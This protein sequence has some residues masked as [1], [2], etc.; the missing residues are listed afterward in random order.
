MKIEINASTVTE[1]FLEEFDSKGKPD[2]HNIQASH[3]YYPRRNTGISEQTLK[4]KNR[5]LKEFGIG[6]IAAFIPSLTG[7]RGPLFEGLPTLER[8]RT[9]EPQ[10]AAKHLFAMGIDDVFFGDGIPAPEEIESVGRLDEKVIE[11]RI[12]TLKPNQVERD[13]IFGGIHHNRPDLAEDVIRSTESRERLK[14]PAGIKPHDNLERTP[15]TV[16]IDNQNYLRYCGELQICLNELPA[17]ARTN[18]VGKVIAA[19]MFLLSYIKEGVPFR[20]KE[21]KQAKS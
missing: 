20:F 12:C 9:M 6:P 15:G 17:D 1:S 19:E 18:V 4:S 13:I 14:D 10:I 21:W 8:H 11:L 16:T 3:N 7:Q 2:Y 5:I